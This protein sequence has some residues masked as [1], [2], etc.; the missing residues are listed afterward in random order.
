MRHAHRE[1]RSLSGF[2]P[3]PLASIPRPGDIE[4]EALVCSRPD[5]CAELTHTR[6]SAVGLTDKSMP[7]L[8]RVPKEALHRRDGPPGRLY[9]VA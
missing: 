9:K 3:P 5:G 6:A 7:S 1:Y 2:R 4:G 8:Q